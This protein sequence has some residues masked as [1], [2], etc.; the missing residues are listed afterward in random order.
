MSNSSHMSL[1]H[2][3]AVIFSPSL[4]IV[5]KVR[6]PPPTHTHTHTRTHSLTLAHNKPLS[7][8]EVGFKNG[9]PICNAY[10]IS[11]IYAVTKPMLLG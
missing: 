10:K 7:S 2:R 8:D 3:L 1:S 5:P 11:H 6:K 9:E 4:I